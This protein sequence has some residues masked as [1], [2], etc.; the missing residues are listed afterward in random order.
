MREI[1]IEKV[2]F[3]SPT[4]SYWPNSSGISD[5]Q[6][7]QY[8]NI[9]SITAQSRQLTSF[10]LHCRRKE[11]NKTN[12]SVMETVCPKSALTTGIG[13]C[14][15]GY[16]TPLQRSH[17]RLCG[18]DVKWRTFHIFLNFV[19]STSGP[20]NYQNVS[21]QCQKLLYWAGEGTSIYR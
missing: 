1:S 16:S 8:L 9:M 12:P 20:Q 7:S 15:L 18:R 3:I 17:A 10:L 4:K 21:V 14:R 11:I 2:N 13:T 19:L 6:I 5:S